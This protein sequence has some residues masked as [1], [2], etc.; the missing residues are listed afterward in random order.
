M[1][2]KDLF[3]NKIISSRNKHNKNEKKRK[4]TPQKASTCKYKKV[5]HDYACGFYI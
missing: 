3:T 1:Y 5:L 4:K 2:H